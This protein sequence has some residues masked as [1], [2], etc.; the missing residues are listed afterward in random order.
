MRREFFCLTQLMHVKDKKSDVGSSSYSVD[1]VLLNEDLKII[2]SLLKRNFISNTSP[3]LYG[4]LP[5]R[6]PVFNAN[7]TTTPTS[8]RGSR[9]A[10]DLANAALLSQTFHMRYTTVGV[11]PAY[12]RAGGN[13]HHVHLDHIVS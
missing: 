2:S 7:L 6:L 8:M 11:A 3:L 10:A 4:L 5:L 12:A 1:R 9:H 13:L